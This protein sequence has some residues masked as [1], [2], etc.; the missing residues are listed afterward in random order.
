[1]R[2]VRLKT[3]IN[4]SSSINPICKGWKESRSSDPELP[5]ARRFSPSLRR[6]L[7]PSSST[8][9]PKLSVRSSC[10][11][12]RPLG[13]GID[14]SFSRRR[15][16]SPILSSS[17]RSP[18]LSS[19]PLASRSVFPSAP[20]RVFKFPSIQGGYDFLRPV[21]ID[22]RDRS[23]KLETSLVSSLNWHAFLRADAGEPNSRN[24]PG[25]G[26]RSRATGFQTTSRVKPVS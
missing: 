24:S 2:I 23:C 6:T 8:P 16:S 3:R 4:P 26:Q 11:P 12:S 25:R 19:S 10:Q 9:A 22:N 5:P 1:M 15:R 13:P 20:D 17:V 18:V 7:I 21:S 14:A